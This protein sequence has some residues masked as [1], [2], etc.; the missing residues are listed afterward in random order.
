MP[1]TLN[2]NSFTI[3]G[4]SVGLDETGALNL[5]KN[6]TP[7]QYIETVTADDSL[8]LDLVNSNIRNFDALYIHFD[9]LNMATNCESRMQLYLDGNVAVDS[10]YRSSVDAGSNTS[11]TSTGLSGGTYWVYGG[12]NYSWMRNIVGTMYVNTKVGSIKTCKADLTAANS[13]ANATRCDFGGAFNYH[14]IKVNSKQ[15]R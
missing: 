14:E 7:W 1:L 4:P 9:N 15:S 11:G 5:I 2:S 13:G 10:Y 3:G 12:A 8:S 6:N